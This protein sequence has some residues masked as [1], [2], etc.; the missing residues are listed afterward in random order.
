VVAGLT[1]WRLAAGWP[2][3]AAA[4]VA[5][6]VAVVLVL[7]LGAAW[8][9][10]GPLSPGWSARAGTPAPNLGHDTHAGAVGAGR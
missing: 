6:V 10:A 5:G 7:V 3:R 2:E 9:K 4:R 1:L 8:L